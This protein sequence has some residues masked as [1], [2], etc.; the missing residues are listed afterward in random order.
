MYE[1]QLNQIIHMKCHYHQQQQSSKLFVFYDMLCKFKHF[2]NK[3]RWK[4]PQ[5]LLGQAVNK[6]ASRVRWK[7]D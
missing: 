7:A 6:G 2:S 1:Q 4:L 3:T 5:M